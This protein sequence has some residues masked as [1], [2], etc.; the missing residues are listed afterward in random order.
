MSN[1]I[2]NNLYVQGSAALV[3]QVCTEVQA[4]ESGEVG[5]VEVTVE[6]QHSED[7]KVCC[8]FDSR[9]DA[10]W[11]SFKGLV[12]KYHDQGVRFFLC[13]YDDDN[14]HRDDTHDLVCSRFGEYYTDL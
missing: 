7:K 10:P 3:D 12:T 5:H 4:W 6:E 13:W 8:L 14:W 9:S 1:T 2:K 11:D